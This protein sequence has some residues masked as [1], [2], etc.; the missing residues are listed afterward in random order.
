MTV[1]KVNV[2]DPEFA[3][4][5][6][7]VLQEMRAA[8]AKHPNWP[9]D[10]VKRAAI[11]MEE[12]GEL[13]C[14]ANHLDEGKGSLKDLKAECIQ[15]VAVGLRMLDA[16]NGD[17]HELANM[18]GEFMGGGRI[19]MSYEVR[20]RDLSGISNSGIYAYDSYMRNDG[21]YYTRSTSTMKGYV[22]VKMK[23]VK[24]GITIIF[25]LNTR[26]IWY[27]KPEVSNRWKWDGFTI[28]WLFLHLRVEPRYSEIPEKIVA[29]HLGEIEGDSLIGC[30]IKQ[31][32]FNFKT[33]VL[34]KDSE[35]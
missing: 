19:K 18:Y 25:R 17:Q 28:N 21:G 20:S 16:I 4:T 5:I 1:L 13:I 15:L 23:Q 7:M 8:Q 27:W 14:E 2:K 32:R 30:F 31:S 29:D 35:G 33:E 24:A 9:T 12:A 22:L 11:V 26:G 3:A 10:N 34:H 6:V